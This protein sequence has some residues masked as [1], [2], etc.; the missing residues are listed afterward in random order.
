MTRIGLVQPMPARGHESRVGGLVGTVVADRL[1]GLALTLAAA[2]GAGLVTSAL[3]PRGPTS[4]LGGL[5]VMA[6][7][8]AL[9]VLGGFL[10]RTSWIAVHVMLVHIATIEIAR[11]DVFGPTID[12][13][14]LDSAYGIIAFV[15]GRGLHGLLFGLPLIFATW[16]GVTLASRDPSGPRRRTFLGHL[17]TSLT[18]LLVAALAVLVALPAS[19]PPIVGPDG[20]PVAGSVAELATVQLG[21]Q[22]QAVMIRAASADKPVLLYLSGGPGQSDLALARALTTGW[23]QDFVFVDLDQ[24]GNGKSFAAIDPV[25]S[26][27]LDRAVSD[28]IEL[29]DY[30][31]TRFDEPKIYLMGESWGTILGVLA[32]QRRPDLYYAWIGSGQMVDVVETDKRVYRDLSA[33]AMRTGDRDLSAKLAEIGAPPY[34]DIPWANANLLTW[35]EY[36]YKP[37]TPSAGYQAR[38]EASGLDPFG[39]TGSEYNLIEKANVLRGLIDTFT[40]MYPQLYALD[41][42]RD[43]TRLEVPVYILDGA[44]EL[45]GRRDLALEWFAQLEAP[46]KQLITYEGAAHS[47]AFEQADEVQRLLNETILPAT[48]RK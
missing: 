6:L 28:V 36:L 24:R 18:G 7:G 14:R 12:A 43:A 21:G 26:M 37:Y 5:G 29:T 35:Y 17:P 41:F 20:K 42:R 15:L 22:D 16:V 40:V 48:Y 27:T 23:V 19:T 11:L 31:R 13:I 46:T 3:M 38:G 2:A 32:V 30:L 4:A 47:V 39:M 34:R 45:T 25:S 44:A 9:G 33:Y 8:L 10:V 1:V